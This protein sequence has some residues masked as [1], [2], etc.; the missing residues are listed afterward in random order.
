MADELNELVDR[1]LYEDVEA[2]LARETQPQRELDVSLAT[3]AFNENLELVRLLLNH[4]AN[5]N[6]STDVAFSA[7]FCAIEQHNV[8][9]IEYLLQ[10]GADVNANSGNGWTP[11]HAAVDIEGD[12][13]LQRHR[14]PTAAVTGLLLNYGA[15]PTREDSSGRTALDIAKHY[16]HQAAIRVLEK[17]LGTK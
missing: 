12:G 2:L 17:A 10:H 4:G 14:E 13:A 11:L 9:I 8:P 16:E 6:P 3:A 1:N 15:D 7:I 5:P